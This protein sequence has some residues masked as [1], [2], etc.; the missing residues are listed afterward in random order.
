MGDGKRWV[1]E[2][3]VECTGGGIEAEVVDRWTDGNLTFRDPLVVQMQ[4][5]PLHAQPATRHRLHLRE[6]RRLQCHHRVEVEVVEEGCRHPSPSH[7]THR[8]RRRTY[9]EWIGPVHLQN[10]GGGPCDLGAV[11]DVQFCGQVHSREV[12]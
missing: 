6:E 1:D 12:N 3:W 7:T 11:G 4:T 8:A 2:G 9:C 5:P 10:V